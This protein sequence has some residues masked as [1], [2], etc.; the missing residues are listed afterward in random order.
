MHGAQLLQMYCLRLLGGTDD[1]AGHPVP[2]VGPFCD[3]RALHCSSI[4]PGPMLSGRWEKQC[5]F[6]TMQ[7]DGVHAPTASHNATTMSLPPPSRCAKG[8]SGL[9]NSMASS[10]LPPSGQE[11]TLLSQAQRREAA[12][13]CREEGNKAFKAGGISGKERHKQIERARPCSMRRDGPEANTVL[14][15]MEPNTVLA[16]CAEAVRWYSQALALQVCSD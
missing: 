12:L 15:C 10:N 6:C 8:R 7:R 2:S 4:G 3:S 16:W 13:R 1:A 14:A 9:L 5:V 11:P